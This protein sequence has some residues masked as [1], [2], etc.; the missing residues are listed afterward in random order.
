MDALI[1]YSGFVG[2]TL[3]RQRRFDECFRSAD[4][5]RVAG[6]RFDTVFCAGISA[7]KWQANRAPDEDRAAIVRL[8]S[9]LSTVECRRFVLISTVDVF[10][11]PIG[12]D[13][14]DA[15]D[16]VQPYGRHRLEA[17]RWARARFPACV[18]VRLPGLVGPGLR[19]NALFDLSNGHRIDHLDPRGVF[20]FYPMVNLWTDLRAILDLGLDTVH[21]TAEPVTLGDVAT[22]VFATT[23]TVPES[24]ARGPAPHYDL[25]TC[26]AGVFGGATGYTYSARESLLAIR[27]YAQG[28]AHAPATR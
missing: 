20:Q 2:S 10:S 9:A 23:L 18:V 19:K 12:V 8:Q 13:E 24:A 22:E 7:T 4:I 27:A 16:A 14:T 3:L 6:R 28:C 21:L 26:H 15:P 25:R 5:G 11:R 17:E 1:G